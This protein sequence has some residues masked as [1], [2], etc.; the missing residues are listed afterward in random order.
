MVKA[1][2]D[3]RSERLAYQKEWYRDNSERQRTRNAEWYAANRARAIADSRK[4]ALANKE[5]VREN[6]KRWREANREKHRQANT[7]YRLKKLYGLTPQAWQRMFD[8][9][10]CVCKCCGSPEAKAKNGW[11][12]DHCHESGLV[13]G[14]LCQ[15]CN[16]MIGCAADDPVTLIKGAEYLLLA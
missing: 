4:W 2:L 11:H 12:V 8:A 1:K 13:R 6:Q 14:I 10:G 9:Q 16:V 5:R 7:K 15:Q 3:K